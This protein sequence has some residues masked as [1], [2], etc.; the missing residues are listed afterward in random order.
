MN[1]DVFL[2]YA[3]EDLSA[4][5]M[6]VSAIEAEGLSVFWD[7]QIVPGQPWSDVLEAAINDSR[8]VV[9][10][11]SAASVKS[12]WVKAEATEAMTRGKLVPVR[13]D[14]AA[15][16]MPFGQVQTAE[17]VPGRPLREQGISI[18][19][20]I[21]ALG[22]KHDAT[23]PLSTSVPSAAPPISGIVD[24][25]HAFLSMEGRLGRRD[26]W[27]CYLVL[28]SFSVLGLMLLEHV[29]GASAKDAPM[30]LKSKVM[31]SWFLMTLYFRIAIALKRLHD[32]GWSG[33]WVLPMAVIGILQAF[34]FPQTESTV[35][36]ER[37]AA[38]F[39]NVLVWIIVIYVGARRGHSGVNRYGAP[40]AGRT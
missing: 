6:L 10:V 35:E 34:A 24:W 32:F 37:Y 18:A 14:N 19:A 17:I 20:A 28:G 22:G 3:R 11:W 15:I 29:T 23:V 1:Y 21:T 38:W 39:L 33:W 16:P 40:H 30:L 2:S 4:V 8:A 13:I 36:A 5:Q 25:R 26:F 12:T 7:R 31:V 27:I 9:V